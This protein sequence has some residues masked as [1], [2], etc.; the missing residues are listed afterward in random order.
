MQK[1]ISIFPYLES[2]SNFLQILDLLW[3]I[4]NLY[5]IEEIFCIIQE[6]LNSLWIL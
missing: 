1:M 6:S 5:K 3:E 4:Y 2:W